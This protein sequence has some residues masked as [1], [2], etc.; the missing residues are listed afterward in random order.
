MKVCKLPID[1]EI[2]VL[3][4][5]EID[6][7]PPPVFR[8][9]HVAINLMDPIMRLLTVEISSKLTWIKLSPSSFRA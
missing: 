2:D 7:P 9:L 8:D 5:F 4:L 3:I 1:V 6:V